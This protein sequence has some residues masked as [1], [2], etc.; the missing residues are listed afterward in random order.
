MSWFLFQVSL[1]FSPATAVP[2]EGN[3][4]TVSAQARSLCGLSAVDQSVL[5]MESGRRLSAEAV[6]MCLFCQKH[7]FNRLTNMP[8]LVCFKIPNCSCLLNLGFSS[9]SEAPHLLYVSL[10]GHP[11]LSTNVELGIKSGD[12]NCA[13]LQDLYENPSKSCLT[14]FDIDRPPPS[15]FRCSTCS[16]C[17]HYQIIHLVLRMSRIA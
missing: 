16:R 1:Q 7:K 13:V 15:V 2:G 12:T 4:L 14:V 9:S 6:T 10:I 11:V 5:I 17:V 8:C 3:L